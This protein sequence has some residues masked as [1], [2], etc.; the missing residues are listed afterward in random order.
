MAVISSVRA[1]LR[2]LSQTFAPRHPMALVSREIDRIES[3]PSSPKNRKI[4]VLDLGYGF[5][6]HWGALPAKWLAKIEIHGIDIGTDSLLPP[7][8]GLTTLQIP[9]DLGEVDDNSFDLIIAFDLIEHLEKHDGFRMLY[10]MERICRHS[11]VIFTPNGILWQPPTMS[12][13]FQAHISSW[14][15][16][17]MKSFGWKN[18]GTRGWKR[19]YGPLAQPKRGGDSLFKSWI[20][21]VP[22]K[23]ATFFPKLSFSFISVFRKDTRY[24]ALQKLLQEK[25]TG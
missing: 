12:N 8:V 4:E 23:I 3:L 5:G 13:P 16:A 17:E 7:A 11:A 2:R 1:S 24:L 19:F 18:Y 14:I 10:H 25:A 21:L 15:P 20:R 6:G 22:D 9:H